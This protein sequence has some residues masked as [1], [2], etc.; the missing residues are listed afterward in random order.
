MEIFVSC[1]GFK[2]PVKCTCLAELGYM[3]TGIG[4]HTKGISECNTLFRK[5]RMILDGTGNLIQ[6]NIE[7]RKPPNKR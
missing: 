6:Q 2:G 5:P 7:R 1:A 3:V 4:V